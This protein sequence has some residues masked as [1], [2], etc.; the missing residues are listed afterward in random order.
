MAGTSEAAG[1]GIGLDA[2]LQDD[3]A[4]VPQLEV[5][6]ATDVWGETWSH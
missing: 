3:A 2:S 4:S 5:R 1:L 6:F